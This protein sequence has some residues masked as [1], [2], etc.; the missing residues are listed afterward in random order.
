M[1]VRHLVVLCMVTILFT[2]ASSASQQAGILPTYGSPELLFEGGVPA[3]VDTIITGHFNCDGRMDVAIGRT[4]FNVLGARF[5]L[6]ILLNTG[7]GHFVD[8]TTSIFLGPPVMVDNPR[9]LL[10]ADF[11][12]VGCDDIFVSDSGFDI[13][14]SPG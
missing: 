13:G 11:N 9:Q 8:A 5:P 3:W 4:L 10:V 2:I 12:G 7:T 14:I 6:Q 1:R